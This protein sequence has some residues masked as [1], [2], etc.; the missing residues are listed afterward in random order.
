M[1]AALGAGALCVALWLCFLELG[2]PLE[3]LEVHCVLY[4][5]MSKTSTNTRCTCS[6]RNTHLCRCALSD[7]R[8]VEMTPKRF[9]AIMLHAIRTG[10][11]WIAL[12]P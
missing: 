7:Q 10:T 5:A 12:L 11:S 2:L 9:G 6:A 3:V 1:T 4:P 8:S